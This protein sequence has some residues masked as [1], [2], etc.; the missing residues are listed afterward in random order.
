MKIIITESVRNKAVTKW[1]NNEYGELEKWINPNGNYRYIHYIDSNDNTIFIYH[2]NTGLVTIED[3]DLYRDLSSMFGVNG[4]ELNNILIPWL[5]ERYNIQTDL[6]KYPETTWHC[7]E[8]GR[9]H[10]TRHHIDD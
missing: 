8:C 7:N 3:E 9:Y 6:I 5:E 2:R 4:Y 10:T 1:L